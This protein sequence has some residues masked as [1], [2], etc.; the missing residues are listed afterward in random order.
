[1][2]YKGFEQAGRTR[3]E[4]M[5]LTSERCDPQTTGEMIDHYLQ[6][7]GGYRNEIV[8]RVRSEDIGKNKEEK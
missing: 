8:E 5:R 1:M 3:E 6:V 2:A 7:H 4:R